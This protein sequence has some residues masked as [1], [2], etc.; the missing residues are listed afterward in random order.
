MGLT[1]PSILS[2]GSLLTMPTTRATI[3]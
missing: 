1:S 2:I 3:I